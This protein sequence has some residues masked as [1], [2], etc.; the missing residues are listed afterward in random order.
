MAW[1]GKKKQKFKTLELCTE[2]YS[3]KFEPI[4]HRFAIT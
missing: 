1:R 3:T 2:Y 4:I